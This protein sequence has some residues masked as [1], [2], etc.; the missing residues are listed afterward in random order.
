MGFIF[1]GGL[2]ISPHKT[3]LPLCN[4]GFGEWVYGGLQGFRE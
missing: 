1:P 2:A 3:K 4:V